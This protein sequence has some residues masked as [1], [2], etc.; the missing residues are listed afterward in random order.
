MGLILSTLGVA[1]LSLA[2]S[3]NLRRFT[4]SPNSYHL[5]ENDTASNTNNNVDEAQSLIPSDYLE[6]QNIS[7]V[8]KANVHN[9]A[10]IDDIDYFYFYLDY[11]SDVSF[12]IDTLNPNDIQAL[13]LTYYYDHYYPNGNLGNVTDEFIQLNTN[14]T[15]TLNPGTYYFYL[16]K[17]NSTKNVVNIIDYTL[18]LDISK[19]IENEEYDIFKEIY[20]KSTNGLIWLNDAFVLNS[21]SLF[22][23]ANSTI[24]IDY[25]KDELFNAY[26]NFSNGQ[27]IKL[28]TIYVWQQD[29]LE[30]FINL[31]EG[32]D[33]AFRNQLSSLQ[34]QE[35]IALNTV[36]IINKGVNVAISLALKAANATYAVEFLINS[37]SEQLFDLLRLC[38]KMSFTSEVQTLKD[39]IININ[40]LLDSFKNTLAINIDNSIT[41]ILGLNLFYSFTN[42]GIKIDLGTVLEKNLYSFTSSHSVLTVSTNPSPNESILNHG[43][44][45][46]F[47]NFNNNIDFS[48]LVPISKIP[49]I[50]PQINNIYIDL[51]LA[52]NFKFRHFVRFKFQA[53]QEKTYHFSIYASSKKNNPLNLKADLFTTYCDAY[54]YENFLEQKSGSFET[55]ITDDEGIYFTKNLKAGDSLLIR[56]NN[57][58]FESSCVDGNIVVGTAPLSSIQHN[59]E[60]NVYSYL[61]GISH[62]AICKCGHKIKEK[63][64]VRIRPNSIG[65]RPS[66]KCAK[67]GGK[68]TPFSPLDP[69]KTYISKS[70]SYYE[71]DILYLTETDYKRYIEGNF[72]L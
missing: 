26:R 10:L 27:K 68:I 32:L 6:K 19:K 71:N 49:Y 57:N 8:L 4:D 12:T 50:S 7:T 25:L 9:K 45:Y 61:D 35:K 23:V 30:S 24:K 2:S 21:F 51:P 55:A 5:T 46:N 44:L 15:Y 1:A 52:F 58:N 65:G 62:Y 34:D 43:H 72:V 59:H 60:Y 63:H 67:C 54:K 42:K 36:N 3:S 31:F 53:E 37:V 20:T 47:T 41:G 22:N 69:Q 11:K 17:C 33:K 56:V 29:A 38:V 39:T 28:A 40:V 48:T 14:Y 64:V 70:G 16:K 13:F 66:R 18:S